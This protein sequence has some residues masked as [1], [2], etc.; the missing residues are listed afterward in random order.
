[1]ARCARKSHVRVQ[2]VRPPSNHIGSRL[3][4]KTHWRFGKRTQV[5]H[6]Y[7]CLHG[8]TTRAVVKKLALLVF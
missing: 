2:G 5:H 4:L 7:W 1:M 8:S 6:P 3:H